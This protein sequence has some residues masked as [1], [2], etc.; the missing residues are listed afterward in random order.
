MQER[1]SMD[2]IELLYQFDVNH[3][4][5]GVY[6]EPYQLMWSQGFYPAL[7]ADGGG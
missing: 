2:F 5:K 7:K 1:T 4:S 3:L 6:D